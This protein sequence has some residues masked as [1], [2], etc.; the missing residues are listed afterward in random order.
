[1]YKT[2]IKKIFQIL[3]KKDKKNFVLA[4]FLLINKSI[5]EVLSIGLLIP[6]LNFLVNE[7]SKNIIYKYVTFLKEYNNN[8]L[9]I[10][11]VLVF[12]AIYLVKTLFIL[13][14][15]R[16][17]A[18]FINTLNINIIQKLLEKYLQKN[19][20]FF[21]EINSATL[22]RNLTVETSIFSSGII[23]Q[24]ILAITHL[25]FIISVCIFLIFYNFYSFYVIIILSILSFLVIKLSNEKFRK[26]G[27][28]R[29]KEN[30]YFIKRLNEV[31]GSIK[32]IILYKKKQFFLN[33]VYKHNKNFADANIYRDVSLSFIGPIIEF[34]GI[35][36]FFSF[37]I[38]LVLFSST[39]MGQLIVLF[40]VFAFASIKLLPAVIGLVRAMQTIKF[41]LPSIKVLED[42][43]DDKIEKKQLVQKELKN[44]LNIE[45]IKFKNVNFQYPAQSKYTL[46]K[47][48]F[49]IKKGD[50]VGLIGETG[51]GKT[52]LLNLIASL[53]KPKDGS[54][55]INNSNYETAIQNFILDIGYVSQSVYLADE[56]VFYNISLK[57]SFSDEDKKRMLEILDSLN[58]RYVNNERIDNILSIGEKG[59]RLSGGQVQRIG[60][61]RA[62]FRDPSILILDEATNALDKANE[63][64][65]LDFIFK[66]F[67]DKIVV[68]CTHKKELLKYCN[69][70]IEVKEDSL[71]IRNN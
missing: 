70:V 18:R 3:N 59:S 60:I 63:E 40:G 5:L 24:L 12:L 57:N 54:I 43:I 9:I 2:S 39:G 45:Q 37:L 19:Y 4:L 46:T 48:N 71:E 30:A 64:K 33:E 16:W 44:K 50:R 65:V 15:N 11:F 29:Q 67:I 25:F 13:F 34:L 51:S 31:I 52:T 68:L 26:W 10:F 8:E 20:N 56:S 7:D 17:N 41:N 58:L 53:I 61:A 22:L 38:I 6:I 1:M 66:K 55:E 47:V 49:E 27:E 21:L 42:L 23:G 32:E 69:K 36:V 62:V 28:V 35:F 14:Y